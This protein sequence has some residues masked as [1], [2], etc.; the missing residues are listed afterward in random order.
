MFGTSVQFSLDQQTLNTL[1]ALLSHCLQATVRGNRTRMS[2]RVDVYGELEADLHEENIRKGRSIIRSCE[3]EEPVSAQHVVQLV[4][5]VL[6]VTADLMLVRKLS[7]DLNFIL[8]CW[9]PFIWLPFPFNF[10]K[11]ILLHEV[12]EHRVNSRLMVLH[13]RRQ[14]QTAT[15]ISGNLAALY[16]PD[17][18]LLRLH[19]HHRGETESRPSQPCMLAI[20]IEFSLSPFTWARHLKRVRLQVATVNS[21]ASS[22]LSISQCFILFI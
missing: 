7:W 15:V 14:N 11:Y 16:L 20:L 22:V 1:V 12:Q 2:S 18:L 13:G 10:Q 6:E 4:T 21:K 3:L 5:D 9:P 19:V 8:L 17:S